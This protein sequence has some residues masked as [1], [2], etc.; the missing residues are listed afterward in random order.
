MYVSQEDR[1]MNAQNGI[2]APLNIT[3]ED[4]I[5]FLETCCL[6]GSKLR[7]SH[8]TD[9]LKLEVHEEA[10]CPDCGIRNKVSSFILQ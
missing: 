8:Q 2:V 3:N 5:E 4:L 10:N 6:C 1:Q 9:Y 7:F